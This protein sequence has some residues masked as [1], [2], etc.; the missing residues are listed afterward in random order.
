MRA[1]VGSLHHVRRVIQ[2][3][4]LLGE[5]S[6]EYAVDRPLLVRDRGVRR[7][8]VSSSRAHASPGPGD[9]DPHALILAAIEP[10]LL[11]WAESNQVVVLGLSSNARERFTAAIARIDEH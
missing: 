9:L 10:R 6:G 7:Q 1:G 11:G 2:L 5:R 3:Q 4:P 8:G